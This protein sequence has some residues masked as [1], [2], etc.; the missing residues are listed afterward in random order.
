MNSHVMYN[1]HMHTFGLEHKDVL[2]ERL[3]S[4]V[5]RPLVRKDPRHARLAGGLNELR[6]GALWSVAAQ[7][8]D[9]SIMA[10]ECLDQSLWTAVVDSLYRD[11][12]WKLAFA[13]DTCDSGN[14]MSAS[15]E[16]GF[17]HE[18]TAVARGLNKY[19]I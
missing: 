9:E 12:V 2:D 11:A 17:R 6:L 7:S 1:G 8:D 14:L 5:G 10:A 15:L 16:Q 18:G 19:S 13:V 3:V 4:R